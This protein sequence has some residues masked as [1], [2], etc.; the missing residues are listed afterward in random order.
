[1]M[2]QGQSRSNRAQHHQFRKRK[3]TQRAQS[4]QARSR[5]A[6]TTAVTAAPLTSAN[7]NMTVKTT[8]S[9]ST[10][11]DP[12]SRTIEIIDIGSTVVHSHPHPQVQ[13]DCDTDRLCE[14]LVNWCVVEHIHHQRTGPTVSEPS[15]LATMD[16][17]VRRPAT[18]GSRDD[19]IN[20]SIV[21]VG[22]TAPDL[23][24]PSQPWPTQMKGTAFDPMIITAMYEDSAVRGDLLCQGL[25]ETL[26]PWL[27]HGAMQNTLSVCMTAAVMNLHAA[28]TF[29][30]WSATTPVS[31]LRLSVPPSLAPRTRLPGNG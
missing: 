8:R 30:F 16:R 9:L 18:L 22:A 26:M 24:R 29:L 1:M 14:S 2:V 19:H 20:L 28:G 5:A 15:P 31:S 17:A 7:R 23:A 25:G 4:Q 21:D 27:I 11:S 13:T 6:V 10:T 3:Q 12:S